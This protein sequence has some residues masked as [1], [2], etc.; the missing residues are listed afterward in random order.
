[1]RTN[2]P[3]PGRTHRRLRSRRGLRSP[4]TAPRSG[5]RVRQ[6]PA[7]RPRPGRG[8]G[9]RPGEQRQGTH[10][11]RPGSAEAAW[12]P[13]GAVALPQEAAGE[14]A[15]RG[16][17]PRPRGPPRPGRHP[18]R[19]R[20]SA[21][22]AGGPFGVAQRARG[23]PPRRRRRPRGPLRARPAGRGGYKGRGHRPTAGGAAEP[24]RRGPASCW[25]LHAARL[26]CR[27]SAGTSRLGPRRGPG[28]SAALQARDRRSPRR[29]DCAGQCTLEIA[30][31]FLLLLIFRFSFPR[32]SSLVY[33][34][35]FSVLFSH[36]L[37]IFFPQTLLFLF[38]K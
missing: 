12:S 5:G 14:G 8:R 7:R 2:P 34:G 4:T 16:P 38:S 13:A 36:F 19:A 37:L 33:G 28:A 23:R 21:S 30:E 27:P 25:R 15:Q 1:M 26:I 24:L 20:G 31:K 6:P 9:L 22:Q 3:D 18:A 35:L 29:Q 17:P 11:T 10:R 32:S